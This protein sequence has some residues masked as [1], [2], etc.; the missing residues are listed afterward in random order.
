MLT[1]QDLPKE[2]KFRV[3]PDSQS[4]SWWKSNIHL[5]LPEWLINTVHVILIVVLIL[6]GSS[7]ESAELALGQAKQTQSDQGGKPAHKEVG[8]AS[9]YGSDFQGNET[10]NGERFD[11]KDLTAA[12][13]SLPMGSKAKVTNLENGKKVDVKINDRGP[14]SGGRVIDLSKAAAK[15]LDMK[16]DGTSQVKIETQSPQKK[17]PTKRAKSKRHP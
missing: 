6:Y 7:C 17:T 13:P 1:I 8:E 9:W 11:Q 14:Y 5:A 16:Q 4:A 15:K 10:A 2:I 3:F 12:H